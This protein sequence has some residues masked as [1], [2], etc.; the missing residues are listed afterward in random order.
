MGY[1]RVKDWQPTCFVCGKPVPY[2]GSMK[3]AYRCDECINAG[4][5]LPSQWATKVPAKDTK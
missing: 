4:R 1:E 5:K 2:L 3:T